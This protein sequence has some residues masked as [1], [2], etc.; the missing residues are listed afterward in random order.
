LL[1]GASVATFPVGADRRSRE[2]N[3]TGGSNLTG[4]SDRTQD[5]L[6]G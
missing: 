6:A 5:S 1:T 4:Q 2:R 3:A